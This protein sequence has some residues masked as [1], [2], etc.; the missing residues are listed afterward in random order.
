MSGKVGMPFTPGLHPRGIGGLF[1]QKPSGLKVKRKRPSKLTAHLAV[2]SKKKQLA[3]K[4][5]PRTKPM[6]LPGG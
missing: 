6:G 5:K 4:T 2:P 1:S 3:K